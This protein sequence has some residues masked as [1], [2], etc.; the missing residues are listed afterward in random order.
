MAGYR[1]LTAL[2]RGYVR[3][4]TLAIV[5]ALSIASRAEAFI[6]F[7]DGFVPIDA[8]RLE[9]LRSVK[10]LAPF[11]TDDAVIRVGAGYDHANTIHLVRFEG[12]YCHRDACVTAIFLDDISDAG[13]STLS[14]LPPLIA[15][16]DTTA[17]ICSNCPRTFPVLFKF[18]DER[19]TGFVVIN[20]KIVHRPVM[21]P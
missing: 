11:L 3:L 16:G 19:Q 10:A 21:G 9:Q 18:A 20:G 4:L 8:A 13:L 5:I 7:R 1:A 14:Q 2:R 17:Q 12:K 6:V 15:V